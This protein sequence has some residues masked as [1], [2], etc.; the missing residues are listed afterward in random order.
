MEGHSVGILEWISGHPEELP[1]QLSLAKAWRCGLFP[2]E[3]F[4]PS[5][6]GLWVSSLAG[7]YLK[8]VQFVFARRCVACRHQSS[9]FADFCLA[10]F[11]GSSASF[12]PLPHPRGFAECANVTGQ[13]RAMIVAEKAARGT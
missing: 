13:D 12:S 8:N 6:A 1:D 9:Q 2:V 4:L 10:L 5:L 7:R 11:A 3:E